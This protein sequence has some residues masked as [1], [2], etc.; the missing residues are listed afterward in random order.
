MS[1]LLINGSP[2]KNGNTAAAISVLE[3]RF[4]KFETDKEKLQRKKEQF[5]SRH[6]KERK[7]PRT[8][9]KVK[10]NLNHRRNYE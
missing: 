10:S 4:M 2:R 6:G 3:N 8:K 5:S 7:N 1:V 9:T